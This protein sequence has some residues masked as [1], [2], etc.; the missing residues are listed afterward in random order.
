MGATALSLDLEAKSEDSDLDQEAWETLFYEVNDILTGY[1]E[2]NLRR[3]AEAGFLDAIDGGCVVE[4][5]CDDFVNARLTFFFGD[6]WAIGAE[7]AEHWY[8]LA[9]AACRGQVE[10]VIG[11]QG[12]ALKNPIE[13][14]VELARKGTGGLPLLAIGNE[15]VGVY[16]DGEVSV[17]EGV[18]LALSEDDQARVQE[19][20]RTRRCECELCQQLRGQPGG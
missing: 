8:A 18:S 17:T 9:M 4:A 2:E 16:E 1:L 6:S 10:Q 11:E 19:A 15:I 14:V 3:P 12:L 13:D 20:A 5:D 7:A